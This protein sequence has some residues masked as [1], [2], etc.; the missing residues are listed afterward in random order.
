[1]GTN[2]KRFPRKP[3][4]RNQ[5]SGVAEALAFVHA[6]QNIVP[7]P[8][9]SETCQFRQVSRQSYFHILPKIIEMKVPLIDLSGHHQSLRPKLLE[10]VAR[11]IDSQQFVLG[12]EV[13][14]LEEEIASYSTT[15]FA[16]GCASG[17]DA[18]LLALMALNIKAGDEVITTPFTF[19]ATGSAITRLGA[20]P[21]F[22]DIDPRTYNINPALVEAAITERTRAILPV[23]IYGQCADM[24]ALLEIAARHDL[25]VVEDAAQAIGAT[26][27]GRRAGAMG[28]LGCFSFYPTKN[29]GAAGDGGMVVTSDESLATRVRKLRVHVGLTEYQHDEV[30]INS[31]LDAMQAAILRVKLKY[32]DEWSEARRNKAAFYDELLEEGERAG[33]F[34][35]PFVRPEARHIFHQ[36]VI[37]VP[38]YR[39]ELIRH[40]SQHGVGNKIYYPVPLHMQ[41][42]FAYLNYKQGEFPESE[43]AS[44]ETVALPCFPEITEQ[45]QCYVAEILSQFV[46]EGEDKATRK[47]GLAGS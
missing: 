28:L 19:F 9:T 39:D 41:Q 36:Y 6:L 40:L 10:A 15:N 5:A 18:L 46:G 22:V 24:D 38:G 16:V 11:V 1:M 45:E 43:R 2:R 34:V 42:C 31:R 17:S 26:D 47:S 27:R 7:A 25:P 30:G 20:R 21:Q 12:S 13:C 23:H 4:R 33:R 44:L 29:L 14:S 37:R 32:L 35:R 3:R 8:Q